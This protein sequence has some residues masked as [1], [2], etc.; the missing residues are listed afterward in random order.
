M[1]NGLIGTAN[2]ANDPAFQ[3]RVQAAM[4]TAA[5]SVAAEAVG[6][7][8]AAT[9]NLRHTLAFQVLGN[10]QAYLYRFAWAVAA[11]VTVTADVGPP[12]GI[13]SS[14]AANPSVITTA[15]VHGLTTGQIIEI[16]GHLVNT[17]VNGT[18]PVTVLTTTT[19]S[20]QAIG[21][22]VGAATGQVVLQPPDSD[23]QFAVNSL[24]SDIAGVGVTT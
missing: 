4:V 20:V 11:N 14:T 22:G 23:I 19:F 24:W 13:A 15:A 7:Q 17:A 6:A 3:S 21:N 2:L 9:Y 1:S 18:F 10:P 5:A 12:L 16:S 8:D